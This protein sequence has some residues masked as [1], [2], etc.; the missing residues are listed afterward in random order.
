M[1]QFC[2]FGSLVR[3]PRLTYIVSRSELP[4]QQQS[5]IVVQGTQKLNQESEV[6][7]AYVEDPPFRSRHKMIPVEDS[8]NFSEHAMDTQPSM[9]DKNEGKNK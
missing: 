6:T 4:V 9:D 7:N 5:N 3:D 2:S 1:E 8:D